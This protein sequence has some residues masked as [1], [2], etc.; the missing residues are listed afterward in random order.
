MPSVII[1]GPDPVP[2]WQPTRG[3]WRWH[4]RPAPEPSSLSL[5]DKPEWFSELPYFWTKVQ[6]LEWI[7]YHVE[8]NKYDASS[9]D[10]S[11]CNM[12]GHA[13][14]HCTRDQMRLIFGPLGDELY[15]RLHEISE[16][17]YVPFAP[18]PGSSKHEAETPPPAQDPML[19]RAL[20]RAAWGRL[21]WEDCAG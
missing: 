16:C 7:S 19:P 20:W 5:A 6:V 4:G 21:H 12:D 8:K 11:C 3:T 14:C 15:D 13:L 9:I 10:F 1:M 2:N 17:P 18:R